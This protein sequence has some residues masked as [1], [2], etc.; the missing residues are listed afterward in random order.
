MTEVKDFG[1]KKE[2][3][4]I[5]MTEKDLLRRAKIL[6]SKLMEVFKSYPKPINDL[7]LNQLI[8]VEETIVSGICHEMTVIEEIVD[9]VS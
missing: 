1:K 4:V 7:E 5:I 9:D 3:K 8:R 6:S 2:E